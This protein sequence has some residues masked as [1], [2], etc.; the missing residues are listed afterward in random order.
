MPSKPSLQACSKTRADVFIELQPDRRTTQQ[1]R[2]QSLAHLDRFAPQIHTV[3]FE[4]VE[5][6]EY[7]WRAP[8]QHLKVRYAIVSGRDRLAVDQTRPDVEGG[9]S[10]CDQREPLGPVD[11]V[12]DQDIQLVGQLVWPF[13]RAFPTSPKYTTDESGTDGAYSNPLAGAQ[14]HRSEAVVLDFVK[15]AR[16]GRRLGGGSREARLDEA[17][18]VGRERRRNDTGFNSA[19]ISYAY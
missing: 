1:P 18:G 15:P 6:A 4:Q 7:G 3:E 11:A 12:S 13:E 9:R 8:P 16:T 10:S 5:R 19:L 17:H 14:H 2:Q